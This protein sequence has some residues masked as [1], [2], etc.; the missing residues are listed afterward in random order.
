MAT[1]QTFVRKITVGVPIRRVIGT[2]PQSLDDLLD[3]EIRNVADGD[4]L[5]FEASSGL[6]KNVST[7]S[8]GNF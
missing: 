8:G 7:L 4:V 6:F 2:D 3:V 1:S 5:Q